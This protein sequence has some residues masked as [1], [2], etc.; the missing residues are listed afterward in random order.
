MVI[1]LFWERENYATLPYLAC[2]ACFTHARTH[3]RMHSRTHALHR[4]FLERA[5]PQ[6]IFLHLNAKNQLA[7]H[8]KMGLFVVALATYNQLLEVYLRKNSYFQLYINFA[9]KN[10]KILFFPVFSIQFGQKFMASLSQYQNCRCQCLT[11]ND[12][13]QGLAFFKWQ[14][15]YDNLIILS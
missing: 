12:Q 7:G 13:V 3:S 14:F 8:P 15:L 6:N 9:V 5:C 1:G 10:Q 4:V 2:F 11:K